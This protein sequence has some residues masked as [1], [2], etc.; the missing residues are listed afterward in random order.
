MMSKVRT[1]RTAARAAVR[2]NTGRCVRV[3]RHYKPRNNPIVKSKIVVFTRIKVAVG[4][5]G[6]P[7]SKSSQLLHGRD[8]L[9]YSHFIGLRDNRAIF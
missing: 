3:S 7:G 5:Q 6:V 4:F 9:F 8:F 1:V 2:T